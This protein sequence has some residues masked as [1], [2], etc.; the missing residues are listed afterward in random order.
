MG[1]HSG[2]HFAKGALQEASSRVS[3][4]LAKCHAVTITKVADHL[5]S[6]HL[7]PLGL[8]LGAELREAPQDLLPI[9][10]IA[11]CLH[12]DLRRAEETSVNLTGARDNPTGKPKRIH[13]GLLGNG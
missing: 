4:F 10:D 1:I 13:L 12:F 7:A 9:L 3:C 5:T 8:A 6:R 2:I 11:E